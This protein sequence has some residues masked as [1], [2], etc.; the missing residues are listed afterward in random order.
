MNL[1]LFLTMTKLNGKN[2]LSFASGVILYQ[3][4]IIWIYPS[5]AKSDGINELIETLPEV[6]KSAIGLEGGIQEFNDY[7]AIQFYGFLFVIIMMVYS[8]I[9]AVQLISRLVDRGSMAYLLSTSVSR[10]KIAFTQAMVLIFGLFVITLSSILGGII[11]VPLLISDVAFDQ[12]TFLQINIVSFLVFAFIG[13][14]CFLFSCMFV[15]EKYALGAAVSLTLV[16]FGIDIISKISE[17]FKWLEM[18]TVF[19]LYRPQEIVKGTYSIVPT[20]I[21]LSIATMIL[22]MTAIV[23][24]KKKDLPI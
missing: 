12:S 21:G 10:T 3:W 13:S 2:L 1:S 24:F 15:D 14:Y 8:I 5:I 9:T 18:I 11:G 22:F 6:Y 16:F 23:I 19:S 4:L 20:A 7:L 17:K